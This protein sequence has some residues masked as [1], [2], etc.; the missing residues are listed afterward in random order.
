MWDQT[1]KQFWS[2]RVVTLFAYR[3]A[4]E[5][6]FQFQKKFI[7]LAIERV[8]DAISLTSINIFGDIVIVINIVVNEAHLRNPLLHSPTVWN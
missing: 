3:R 5:A 1:E 7:L 6:K 4:K 8:K 2:N